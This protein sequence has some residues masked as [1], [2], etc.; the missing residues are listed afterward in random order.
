LE[1]YI[2]CKNGDA[3][4]LAHLLDKNPDFDLEKRY[5]TTR[6]VSFNLY[7]FYDINQIISK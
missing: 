3:E 6:F 1:I 7:R 2:S 4:R 5:P